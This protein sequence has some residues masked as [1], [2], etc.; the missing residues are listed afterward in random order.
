M[1]GADL[2]KQLE[3]C[4][5]RDRGRLHRQIRNA[6]AGRGSIEKVT[7]VIERSQALRAE[8]VR[9]LPKPTYNDQLPVAASREEIADAIRA[10][11][12]IV[13]CG[14]TGSGKSTQLP[15]ICMSLGRGVSGLI[16]HTQPR[17][18]AARSVAARVAEE[19]G[20]T[21]GRSVGFKVRFT[22]VTSDKSFVKVMTDGVLLAETQSDR[23]LSRYDTIIIDEAHERS[24]NI[25]FLLGYLKKL[26]PR[27][28]DL[29]VIVMSAT[30]DPQRFSEPFDNAPIIEVEGRTY[31]VEVI[32]DPIA[33]VARLDRDGGSAD[34]ICDAVERL[35]GCDPPGSPGDILVFL[36][37]EREIRETAEALRS[38]NQK[39]KGPGG[40]TLCEEIM[41]LYARLSIAQQQRIFASHRGRR[42]VLATNVA[43]T[44][45]TVPGIRYVIDPGF[46]RVS[47]YSARS[48]VQRLPIEAISRASADQRKGRC[49]RTGPGVCVRLYSQDDYES[50]EL[51]T[52]PEILR[53]SLAGVILRMKAL[54]L[55]EIE[56][57][58]FLE[59]PKDAMVREGL[60][61]LR[62]IRAIEDDGRLT[63]VGRALA[64][65]PIDPRIG[66]MV[67]AA[68]DEGCLNEVLIIASALSV[69]DPRLRPM[70]KRDAA[71]E[72]HELFRHERSDFLTSLNIWGFYHERLR[73]LSKGKARRACEQN[74]L[75]PNRMRE[76]QEVHVQL[77]SLARE[78]GLKM[79]A[80]EASYEA[81]HRALL[82]G[83][84]TSVGHR[85]EKGEYE[86]VRGRR[87]R[88]FPGSGQADRKPQ[89]I[90]AAE[91]VETTRL[92]AHTIAAVDPGWIEDIAG[93]LIT[94]SHAD[95]RWEPKNQSVLADE[96]TSLFGLTLI[97]RRTVD[98]GRVNPAG[99]REIFIHGALVEGELR[100]R[101]PF[102]E[103]NRALVERVRALEAKER[104]NDLL[105]DSIAR[106]SFYDRLLGADVWN[107]SSFER[108]RKEAERANKQ[109][110]FMTEADVLASETTANADL[111][112]DTTQVGG[113]DVPLDYTFQLGD[114]RDGVT[115]EV[116]ITSLMH[117]SGA[118]ASWIVPGRVEEKA[119]ELIRSLPK[120]YRRH[121]DAPAHAKAFANAVHARPDEHQGRSMTDAL[122]AFLA[123]KTGVSVPGDA[124]DERSL[125]DHLRMRISVIDEAGKTLAEGRD[126]DAIK[127]DLAPRT[128]Q[129]LRDIED[130]R[131]NRSGI[132]RWDF[133]DLPETVDMGPKHAPLRAHP[134]LA[135][136]GEG[137]ALRLFST[138]QAA[139]HA[140][141]AG[142][143]LLMKRAAAEHVRHL[144]KG[145]PNFDAMKLRYATIGPAD[146][147]RREIVLLII[148]EAMLPQTPNQAQTIRTETAFHNAVRA[149]V[150]RLGPA[151]LA[152]C[153]IVSS[154]LNHHH[155]VQ[156]RLAQQSPLA[157]GNVK[158]DVRDQVAHLIFP[159]S[160]TAIPRRWLRHVPRYLNAADHRLSRL[161]G[162]GLKRDTRIAQTLTP[163]R[164]RLAQALRAQDPDEHDP[165]LET[166][167]WMIE[168]YRVSLFAQELGTA[169]PVSERRLGEQ[170]GRIT[171]N[172]PS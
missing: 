121:F 167:R 51:F 81:I 150:D 114:K 67:L 145:L 73:T 2:L 161:A 158:A 44:S 162:D 94:R 168:E 83:L 6:R 130:D 77:T 170:W 96:K 146:E 31:P 126:I 117:T 143:R 68:G 93:D 64:R 102:F 17:R 70:D 10:H 79:N 27:R 72:A 148:E 42:V 87:F 142:L 1:G 52:P 11:Q 38:R 4:L 24:L 136:E 159:G 28:P 89:W 155:R 78:A 85:V 49:G 29:K 139:A 95:P 163:W 45:L 124:W 60:E 30:I 153:N 92:Y 58:P 135:A 105:A 71:D 84:V 123:L 75:S 152:V 141:R 103:H 66:R 112:P 20:E 106:F 48:R 171:N 50:R 129:S 40:S 157:W 133:G 122:C 98:F 55:G 7:E 164:A 25:D 69:Q 109:L 86:G 34:A 127:A 138:P 91:I 8:R 137:V 76:W 43:E 36:S 172:R 41:P 108:W 110:L 14:E 166:F 125:P 116:P 33:D 63:K 37:G 46:A 26:L 118:R 151:R 113:L 134:A 120:A 32:Y 62:E 119:R 22:D 3:T 88:L 74:Y 111:F 65:L 115:L 12:V 56:S 101:G 18:I 80:A 90:L 57:F 19:I 131:W 9:R 154:I 5:S 13:L 59:R 35:A 107:G 104:R 82:T 15:K 53:T 147:L 54:D 156:F 23:S 128:R 140:H 160:L 16:G 21:L 39:V 132:E 99:A 165:D 47:R 61:T 149:G 97:P 100:T 169:T 144:G